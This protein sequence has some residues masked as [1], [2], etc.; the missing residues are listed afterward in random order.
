M[1][2]KARSKVT[3]ASSASYSWFPCFPSSLPYFSTKWLFVDKQTSV[4]ELLLLIPIRPATLLFYHFIQEIFILVILL[5]VHLLLFT[6]FLRVARFS[7]PIFSS[8]RVYLVVF[9]FLVPGPTTELKWFAYH[10]LLCR[11]SCSYGEFCH[12]SSFDSSHGANQNQERRLLT[13]RKSPQ[14]HVTLLAVIG[15]AQRSLQ[16]SLNAQ[17]NLTKWNNFKTPHTKVTSNDLLFLLNEKTTSQ[18]QKD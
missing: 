10:V 1:K 18:Q 8:W 3:V 9:Y 12:H 5:K 15:L 13:T 6:Q 11:C 16:K 7:A 14:Y 2:H 4:E 17:S